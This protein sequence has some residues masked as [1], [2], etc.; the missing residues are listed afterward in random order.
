MSS[1]GCR[2][3]TAA[4]HLHPRGARQEVRLRGRAWRRAKTQSKPGQGRASMHGSW[5]A[6]AGR[7]GAAAQPCCLSSSAARAAHSPWLLLSA[8][9]ALLLPAAP[10][11]QL[12]MSSLK[13]LSS[14]SSSCITSKPT[15]TYWLPGLQRGSTHTWAS[16]A[17]KRRPQPQDLK[18]LAHSERSSGHE[19]TWLSWLRTR[20]KFGARGFRQMHRLAGQDAGPTAWTEKKERARLTQTRPRCACAPPSRRKR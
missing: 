8:A 1:Q 7:G 20:S 14:W 4:P 12:P 13:P 2:C 15:S 17:G 3:Q 11:V 18:A 5:R 9:T 19:N 6:I 16:T 10:R